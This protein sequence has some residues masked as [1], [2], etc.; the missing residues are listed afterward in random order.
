MKRRSTVLGSVL[1]V[2]IAS[3]A[4]HGKAQATDS[5]NA[6]WDQ[7]KTAVIKGDKETVAALS[8]FPI[9]MSFGISSI[10]NKAQLLRRYREVFNQQT[11]AAKCF[12]KKSPEKD[13]AKYSIACPDEAGN[14]VVIYAFERTKTGWKFTGLDNLNE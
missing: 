13:R 11:N 14:E 3:F 8:R 7:F 4:V 12:E 1:L 2:W 9:G 10:R 6:F 5:F